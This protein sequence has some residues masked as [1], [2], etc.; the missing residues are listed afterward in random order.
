MIGLTSRRALRWRGPIGHSA[1]AARR[2]ND[3]AAFVMVKQRG[4]PDRPV[5]LRVNQWVIGRAT[6]E[7]ADVTR[8]S[9]WI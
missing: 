3:G 1:H 7:G 2:C 9:D 5:R 8:L 4:A 6:V